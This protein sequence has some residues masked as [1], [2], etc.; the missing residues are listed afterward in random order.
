M[1]KMPVLFVGHGSPMN[2]IEENEFSTYWKSLSSLLPEP[3]AILSISAHWFVSGL[4]VSDS[5]M[6]KTIHD[7]YGFPE[8]LFAVEYPAPGSPKFAHKVKDLLQEDV[9]IDNSW[10]TDHGT[11]SVLHRMYPK[12]NIPVFQLSVDRKA[13][14][15]EYYNIGKKIKTLR[16][17]GVLIFGSGNIVHNL[18][19]VN[20]RMP[21]KG[22]E[23][24]YKFDNYIK[25][26]IL[27]ANHDNI[28]N[29]TKEKPFA[30]LSVP[31]IDH[32][33]PLL[34]I[35]GAT[36]KEDKITVFNEACTLGTLSM[37]SYLFK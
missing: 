13:T 22:Y 34:Y 36:S 18:M 1:N 31:T 10:G 27:K 35:L 33:A 32:F 7:F 25:E 8:E 15:Q 2:A 21:N 9:S 28:I 17:E 16:D 37:T 5:E 14:P 20:W 30:E 29:Y 23:W 26:N 4:K 11:W 24:A 19:S 3:K 6:P 12:A